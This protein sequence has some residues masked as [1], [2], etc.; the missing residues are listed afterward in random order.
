MSPDSPRQSNGNRL[1]STLTDDLPSIATGV[2]VAMPVAYG[3][4]LRT[5]EFAASFFVLLLAGVTVPGLV[6]R[7]GRAPNVR[8]AVRWT[9]VGCLGVI[10]TFL[11]TFTLIDALLAGT[12]A[13][14]IAFVVVSLG[15]PVVLD[16]VTDE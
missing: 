15:A 1:A 14:A 6:D 3:V 10:V 5:G 2:V 8:S 4:Q 9:I 7:Y 12:L 11:V 13:A 16:P